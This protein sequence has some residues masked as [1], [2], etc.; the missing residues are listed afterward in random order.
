MNEEDPRLIKL[1]EIVNKM[2]PDELEDDEDSEN[3]VQANDS[4]SDGDPMAKL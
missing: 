2:E 4:G 3:E 1:Y